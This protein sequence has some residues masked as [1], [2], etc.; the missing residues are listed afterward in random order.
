MATKL[1]ELR[2]IEAQIEEAISL[3]RAEQ[4][5]QKAGEMNGQCGQHNYGAIHLESVLREGLVHCQL[6][7]RRLEERHERKA[8]WYSQAKAKAKAT[9]EDA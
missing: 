3:W 5:A 9:D 8:Q 4:A 7:R 2:C 6:L 1:D